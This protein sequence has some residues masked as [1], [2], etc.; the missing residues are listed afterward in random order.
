M[1]TDDI[2]LCEIIQKEKDNYI[3]GTQK[4]QI[5]KNGVEWWFSGAT[6]GCGH[7]REGRE[8]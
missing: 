7:S 4:S 2:R 1:A 6:G 5:C 8:E 3:Y